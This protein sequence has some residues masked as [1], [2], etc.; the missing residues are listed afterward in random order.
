MIE[1]LRIRSMVLRK[2]RLRGGA[3]YSRIAAA[4]ALSRLY[5]FEITAHALAIE[6]ISREL[7]LAGHEHGH[8]QPVAALEGH[9]AVDVYGLH[10]VVGTEQRHEVREQGFAE[11]ALGA[12]V[13]RELAHARA[14]A[15][16]RTPRRRSVARSR[17]RR[18]GDAA[19]NAASNAAA[20]PAAAATSERKIAAATPPPASTAA[21]G[22]P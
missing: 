12:A 19:S 4:A 17:R 15:T 20:A 8:A 5:G 2:R 22:Q 1:K 9:A 7:D 13:E 18:S 11:M 10:A 6:W 16:G 14:Q 3:D 21:S